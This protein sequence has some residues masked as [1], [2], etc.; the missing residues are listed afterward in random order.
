MLH[1][2]TIQVFA[3]HMC[4]MFHLITFQFLVTEWTHRCRL[5]IFIDLCCYFQWYLIEKVSL[6]TLLELN[7]IV[8]EGAK[9]TLVWCMEYLE[10][11]LD[12][13]IRDMVKQDNMMGL[14]LFF[15]LMADS[16]STYTT[17][18]AGISNC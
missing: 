16:K 15:P 4:K 6:Q 14:Y 17:I 2:N 18:G 3:Y 1:L 13:G 12:C 10:L 7:Q 11:S 9:I 5:I 8:H